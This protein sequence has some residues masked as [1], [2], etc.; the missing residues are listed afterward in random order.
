MRILLI[1]TSSLGDII[2]TLPAL[3][4]LKKAFPTC[5]IDW[6]IEEN[7]QEIPPWHPGIN[8]VIPVALRRWRKKI[9]ATTHKTE[10]R[11]FK[12]ELQQK[13]YD[14]VIDAQ[15]LLKSAFL[16][17]YIDGPNYGYDKKSIREPLASLFYQHKISVSKNQHAIARTR[18]L[19][20]NI[21]SYQ[22]TS[23]IDYGIDLSKISQFDKLNLAEKT[24]LFLHGTTWE[25]KRWPLKFWIALGRILSEHSFQVLLP[26]GNPA[27]HIFAQNIANAVGPKAVVLPRLSLNEMASII[28]QTTGIVAVDTGLL[29]LAAAFKKPTISLYGPT[30]PKLTGSIG[31]NQRH[32]AADFACA[33]CL[34]KKCRYRGE[35]I[36]YSEAT[37]KD[38]EINPACFAQIN[39]DNVWRELKALLHHN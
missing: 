14:Y 34:Q 2:H 17:K 24:I 38:Y 6:V 32:L 33:P 1:K 11:S 20:A 31:E 21:F 7:F 25:S 27:E 5:T 37:Q 29:H 13:K 26:W 28:L 16:V 3:T 30:N 4:D 12:R 9:F 18:Q 8:R 35:K 15:G 39:P 36:F 19:F 22:L 10:W 23:S